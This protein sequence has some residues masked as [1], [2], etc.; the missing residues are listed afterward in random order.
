[1]VVVVGW[2]EGMVFRRVVGVAVG[3]VVGVVVGV[4]FHLESTGGCQEQGEVSRGPGPH[5]F[6]G[7]HRITNGTQ[8]PLSAVIWPNMPLWTLSWQPPA[9]AVGVAVVLPRWWWWRWPASGPGGRVC[10]L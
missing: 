10:L 4:I 3:V 7:P 1:M 9:P 8:S 2:M 6:I 5:T